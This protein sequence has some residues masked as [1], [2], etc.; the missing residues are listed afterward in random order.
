M[1]LEFTNKIFTY[2]ERIH[3]N[4][5]VFEANRLQYASN[6]SKIAI[7]EKLNNYFMIDEIREIFNMA[8]L[9]NGEGQKVMQD[10]NHI[11]NSIANEYQVGAKAEKGGEEN[12]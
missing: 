11:D 9:P 2:G 4:K 3:G 7:A 5:I 12:E 6:S 1:G 8:P 10:L